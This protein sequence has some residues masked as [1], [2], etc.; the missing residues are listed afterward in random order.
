VELGAAL[1]AREFPGDSASAFERTLGDL[2]DRIGREH[3]VPLP[4]DITVR[5]CATL[6][7]DGYRI[8][9]FDKAVAYGASLGNRTILLAD[10]A[11]T[12]GLGLDAKPYHTP[13]DHRVV[14]LVPSHQTELARHAGLTVLSPRS[15][16]VREFEAAVRQ[17]LSEFL[18]V[19]ETHYLLEQARRSHPEL[20][21]AITP[22]PLSLTQL[23]GV[24]QRLLVEQVSLCDLRR[25]LETLARWAS[26][27]QHPLDLAEAVRRAIV[28]RNWSRYI[29][30]DTLQYFQLCP[31]TEELIEAARSVDH[32]APLVGLAA[33]TRL[34]ILDAAVET[35]GRRPASATQAIVITRHDL[36]PFVRT[37]LAERLPQI[38]VLSEHELP[39]SRLARLQWI[40]EVSL[41]DG[42][43]GALTSDAALA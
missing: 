21:E 13:W 43:H 10:P 32:E 5:A 31:E 29:C 34:A 12:L 15:V 6:A 18:G 14:S 35:I 26:A 33:E 23:T 39:P 24:F 36:R 9:V 7:A 19:Q 40:G 4:G 27:Q 38:V 17:S 30:G 8:L 2:V 28:P 25:V 11:H 1:L 37:L 22:R 20:V 3:G 41:D 42:P 16:V